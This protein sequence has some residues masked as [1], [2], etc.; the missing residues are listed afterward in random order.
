MAMLTDDKWRPSSIWLQRGFKVKALSR[1]PDM[2]RELFGSN[3]SGLQVCSNLDYACAAV[4][5]RY[6][7]LFNLLLSRFTGLAQA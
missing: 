7:R 6:L 2:A 3:Q 5:S 4:S 1:K